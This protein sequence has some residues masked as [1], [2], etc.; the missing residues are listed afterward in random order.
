M[1]VCCHTEGDSM[2]DAMGR[3]AIVLHRVEAILTPAAPSLVFEIFTTRVGVG[4][5]PRVARI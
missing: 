3:L 5:W 1:N 2:G 4:M